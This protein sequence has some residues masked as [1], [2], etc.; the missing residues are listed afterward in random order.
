MT[1]EQE[2]D[3]DEAD[4]D[5]NID[6]NNSRPR[7]TIRSNNDGQNCNVNKKAKR[8]SSTPRPTS[9]P[10][11]SNTH[12]KV[13]HTLMFWERPSNLHSYATH[14]RMASAKSPLRFGSTL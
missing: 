5:S 1:K 12:Y 6:D 11:A 8:E 13:I 3:D 10:N 9:G 4:D 14:L 2:Y 7:T